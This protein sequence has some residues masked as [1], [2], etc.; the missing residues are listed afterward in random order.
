MAKKIT[1]H[2]ECDVCG[3]GTS[4]SVNDDQALPIGWAEITISEY[5]EIDEYND[6]FS[7]TVEVCSMCLNKFMSPAVNKA[8]VDALAEYDEE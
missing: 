7:Y 5:K 8:R 4:H 3:N 2:Y 6:Y 1:T